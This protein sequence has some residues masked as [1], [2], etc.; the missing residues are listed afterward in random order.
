MG[1]SSL[2]TT[3][4]MDKPN[5][6]IDRTSIAPGIFLNSDSRGM[7]NNCSTSCGAKVGEVV[8]TCT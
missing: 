7:V 3:V 6:E 5:L 4:I 1:M 8:T 2:N